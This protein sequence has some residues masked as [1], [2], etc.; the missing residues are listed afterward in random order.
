MKNTSVNNLKELPYVIGFILVFALVFSVFTLI[1]YPQYSTKE[2]NTTFRGFY[3]EDRNSLDVLYIGSCN[4]YTSVSPTLIWEKT[5]ITGYDITSPDQLMSTS[6]YFLKDAL[7]TQ[8]P[9][10][11]FLESLFFQKVEY[12]SAAPR[13]NHFALDY[14]P[15]SINKLKLIDA[16]VDIDM[17]SM[18]DD[19]S[20]P[21]RFS[22]YM[23]YLFP[24]IKYHNRDDVVLSDVYDYYFNT[25]HTYFNK[26]GWGQM[27]YS[28]EQ[29]ALTWDYVF[30][31]DKINGTTEEYFPKIV[32]LCKENGIRL[33]VMKSPNYMRWGHDD[34]YTKV[35]REYVQSFGVPYLDMMS[36]EFNDF[37]F[38]DYGRGT[39]R[40]N[41]YGMR[42]LSM[43]L[44][45]YLTDTLG[46]SKTPL[47][48]T[49]QDDWQNCVEMLYDYA[50]ETDCPLDKGEIARLSCSEDGI[51][52]RWNAFD[53]C[54]SYSIYRC[55]GKDGAFRLLASG[56][57]GV[58]YNDTE[59]EPCRGYSYYVV[60][61]QGQFKGHNS[62]AKYYIFVPMTENLSAESINGKLRLTWDQPDGI[63]KT[64]LMRRSSGEQN[65]TNYDHASGTGAMKYTNSSVT[66]G[67]IFHYRLTSVI[68]EDGVSY[69]SY[70]AY[71]EAIP[72]TS[73]QLT[74]CRGD[75]KAGSV[76]LEWKVDKNAS[77]IL[78]YR[79]TDD[80][81]F[82]C[83]ANVDGEQKTYT[84]TTAAAGHKY[85]Y[86]IRSAVQ[87]Y[88][89]KDESCLS[90]TLVAQLRDPVGMSEEEL[91]SAKEMD[92]QKTDSYKYVVDRDPA[93][94]APR[95]TLGSDGVWTN[96][97]N[98]GKATIMCCGD[99]MC[100]PDMSEAAY[101]DGIYNF[102]YMFSH[103]RPILQSSDLAI[104]NLE[105]LVS[106]N[107]PY[108][109]EM[110]IVYHHEKDRYHCNAP[111]S[112]LDSLRYAGFDAFA[113]AN[114]HSMDGAYTGIV[115]TVNNVDSKQFMRT[116]LFKNREDPRVI[117]ANVNGIKLG[118]LS[119][120]EHINRNMQ[121]EYLTELGAKTLVNMYSKEKLLEDIDT[122]RAKGAEFI[123]V[124]VHFRCTDY[125]TEVTKHQI[126]T[127]EEIANA[128][129][130]CIM[131]SH[132]HSV[133]PYDIIS[134]ADGRQ[135]P[136][137]YS[138]S[139]FATSD[140]HTVSRESIIYELRLEK[141]D[142]VVTIADEAYI[143]CRL[144]SG[145]KQDYY[146]I[147]P[148]PAAW[149][150]GVENETLQQAEN[151]IIASIGSK[152]KIDRHEGYADIRTKK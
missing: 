31:G 2:E 145:M 1:Y 106:E 141:N 46:L 113:M 132:S 23:C 148:T 88:L 24:M 28:S 150:D 120:T 40:L 140:G 134:T 111:L 146:A 118:I 62:A 52:V 33:V 144:V 30:N 11:V 53:D 104:A 126:A 78:V 115:D 34:S 57:E 96:G 92:F 16:L 135:V 55:E 37:A 8:S 48:E 69:Y 136:V 75:R 91:Y 12:G 147:W 97:G 85:T 99:L 35:S 125:S 43:K 32:E 22:N 19:P 142:G 108:A 87:L 151:D 38:Y 58:T 21:N 127:A 122:A 54:D 93:V 56:V 110:H 101:E 65:Y 77:E 18:K 5:G 45:S 123:L 103:V 29:E 39:G 44:A 138:L 100:E 90:N 76:T 13:H 41:I 130:D 114:N 80:G 60:P 63:E 102:N 116:G 71:T 47:T 15:F 107:I 49:Q 51:L 82:S 143:P 128:G 72:Q 112:Y 25:D 105:T 20:Y 6:Y 121:N 14:M 26:G 27:N 68:E 109:H 59:I 89:T 152:I 94:D 119:Y 10:V 95:F 66:A 131:G 7:R 73:P 86:A 17:E 74:S 4:M 137:V 124:Y 3:K 83:I 61:E 64:K 36:D 139:N 9:K 98:T 133:Q 67:K 42:K 50:E 70:P 84:D 81:E 149:T 117:V 79:M 129:A